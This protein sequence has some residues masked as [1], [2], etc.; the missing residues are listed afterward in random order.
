[1]RKRERFISKMTPDERRYFRLRCKLLE[2]WSEKDNKRLKRK[3]AKK[4]TAAGRPCVFRK[5]QKVRVAAMLRIRREGNCRVDYI[6]NDATIEAVY[7]SNEIGS[8]KTPQVVVV[9]LEA[10][11]HK[12]PV[13]LALPKNQVAPSR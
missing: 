9:T 7:N 8:R 4:Y 13:V 6:A 5:G 1:L 11:R 3:L 12:K 2:N 10:P